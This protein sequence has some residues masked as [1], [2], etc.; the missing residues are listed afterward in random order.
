[1]EREDVRMKKQHEK[2]MA[3]QS[4]RFPHLYKEKISIDVKKSQTSVGGA[5]TSGG[6]GG[7]KKGKRLGV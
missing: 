7:K 1:M 6:F 5:R 2:V 3:D 4:A